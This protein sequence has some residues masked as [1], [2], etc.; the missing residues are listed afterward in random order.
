MGGHDA[1]RRHLLHGLV[2]DNITL[3]Q[4]NAEFHAEID[5]LAEVLILTG[6]A[7]AARAQERAEL[8]EKAVTRS[9]Q[10]LAPA[11]ELFPDLLQRPDHSTRWRG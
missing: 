9:M 8:R 3:Y 11:E 7:I 1:R 4:N 2:G 5:T 10:K 6:D